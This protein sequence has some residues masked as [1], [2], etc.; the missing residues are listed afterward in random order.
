VVIG[1]ALRLAAV[2]AAIVLLATGASACGGDEE[3]TTT[4]SARGGTKQGGPA[5]ETAS[6]ESSKNDS[7]DS[8]QPGGGESAAPPN[9]GGSDQSRA[10]SNSAPLRVSGG[11]S[12]QYRTRGGDNS[13]QN[14]G[15]EADESEL[16]AAAEAVHGFYVARAEEEWSRAC[17]Y[18][19]QSMRAQLEQLAEQS[20]Q[21]SGK[22]CPAILQALTRPLSASARRETTVVDAGSLRRE[23]ERGFL[24]YYGAGR[25][26]YAITLEEE[27][28]AWRVASLA[29]LPIS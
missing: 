22:E 27:G 29:P 11:G 4:A 24:I 9:D 17:S 28:G 1:G 23:G 15:E 14:F 21:L 13:I 5:K 6:G 20:P 26:V 16:E 18:L 7:N 3:T 10:D 25:T 12:G 2:V 8:K 19:A